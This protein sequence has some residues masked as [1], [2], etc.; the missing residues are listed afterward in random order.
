MDVASLFPALPDDARVWIYVSDRA[1]TGEEQDVL[2]GRMDD[3]IEGWASH[4]RPVEGA[5]AVLYD[6]FLVIAATVANGEISGCGI[7][8]S[9]QAVKA[10][11]EALTIHWV[12]ALHVIYRDADG[13][14]RHAP[15]PTFRQL[16]QEGAVTT[17]TPVFD[18]SVTTL[19]ALRQGAFEQPAGA[20]W[21]ARVFDLPTPA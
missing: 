17:E 5:A 16:A 9:T 15:R 18:P 21:H 2:L 11:A 19:G 20:A 13:H 14:V 7:D 4:G 8:A 12:P 3:F 10:A 1:L 6:R